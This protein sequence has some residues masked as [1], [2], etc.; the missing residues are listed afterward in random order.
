M[1]ELAEAISRATGKRIEFKP[2]SEEEYADICRVD[3]TP[4]DLIEVLTS[5]YRAV[6][7]GEFEKVTDHV[8]RLTGT[9]PEPVESYIKRAVQRV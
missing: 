9:P 6:D 8:E 3:N 5:M 4:E 1:P 7:N 2:I